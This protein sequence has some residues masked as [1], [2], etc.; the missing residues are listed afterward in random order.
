MRKNITQADNAVAVE[1]D[2]LNPHSIESESIDIIVSNPPYIRNSDLDGLQK[3]VQFEP[4]MALDGGKDG[5]DFYKK[6]PELWYPYLKNNGLIFFEIS[7]EQ[8]KD[9][10]DILNSLGYS[11]VEVKKDMYGNDRIVSAVKK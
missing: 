11:N 6:I 3:E 2:V 4:K 9:V 10:S 5:L 1:G 8:G 7:E